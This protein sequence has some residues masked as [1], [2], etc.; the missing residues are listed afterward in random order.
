MKYVIGIDGG[1]TKTRFVLADEYGSVRAV[2]TLGGTNYYLSG[3]DAVIAILHDGIVELMRTAGLDKKSVGHI[4]YALAGMDSAEDVETLDRRLATTG[5][6]D[7]PHTIENDVW[8]AF[9]A[10]TTLR[11]GAISICGTGH[12]TGVRL[13]TG[14]TYGIP[15]YRYPLGNHGGGRD[16]CD[17]A[18]N[19]AYMS[20]DH[21]GPQTELEQCVARVCECAT[22]EELERRVINSQYTYQYGYPVAKAVSELAMAG[23]QVSRAILKNMGRK[24]GRMTGCLATFAGIASESFPVILA[25]SVYCQ[26]GNAFITE[27]Y[28]EGISE[29]CPKAE[30][31]ILSHDPAEGAVLHALHELKGILEVD[32]ADAVLDRIHQTWGEG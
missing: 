4:C 6:W 29:S 8:T 13:A 17:S 21:T 5:L 14:I 18:L 30:M 10:Q 11:Q 9:N 24:Q 1:G 32:R 19:A 26:D 31:Q 16:I 15:S 2:V 7:I 25:G 27:G 3:I 12:N 23:D 20:R 28:K 22:L